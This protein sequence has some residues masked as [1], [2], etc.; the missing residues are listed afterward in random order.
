VAS[1]SVSEAVS[2]AASADVEVVSSVVVE[3]AMVLRA[4]PKD[5]TDC[6]FVTA[7]PQI[8][9]SLADPAKSS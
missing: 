4:S 2:V 5:V 6:R 3:S 9:N 8:R 1:C 7:E